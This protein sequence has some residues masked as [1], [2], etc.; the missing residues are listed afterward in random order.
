MI[1]RDLNAWA[2]F[3]NEYLSDNLSGIAVDDI[4]IGYEQEDELLNL[5]Q[6]YCLA[7]IVDLRT[8][9]DQRTRKQRLQQLKESIENGRTNVLSFLKLQAETPLF[10][11]MRDDVKRLT[12]E[13]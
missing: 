9:I 7:L 1:P 11:W 6:R 5:I 8:D 10:P 2:E 4:L 3:L 13:G 12:D